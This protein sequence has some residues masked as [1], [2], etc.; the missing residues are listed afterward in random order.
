MDDLKCLKCATKCV[1][2]PDGNYNSY[3]LLS[4]LNKSLSDYDDIFW[5][6]H[7]SLNILE[8][9]SGTKTIILA[10]YPNYIDKIINISTPV[11]SLPKP[12]FNGILLIVD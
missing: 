5:N 8:G 4:V 6:I 12:G 11:A 3:D 10:P 9:A 1:I 2:I 7:F